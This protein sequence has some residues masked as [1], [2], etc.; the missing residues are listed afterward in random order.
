MKPARCA[1]APRPRSTS[2]LRSS[3]QRTQ[4]VLLP[5]QI[6]ANIARAAGRPKIE[7]AARFR[8]RRNG[9]PRGD[10]HAPARLRFHE[11]D[12][13]RL[14]LVGRVRV[15]ACRCVGCCQLHLRAHAMVMNT[16]LLKQRLDELA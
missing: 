13:R 16:W 4:K 3:E 6:L 5:L 1:S 14:G 8:Q 12:A 11:G 7:F 10:G 9:L 15:E 2:G